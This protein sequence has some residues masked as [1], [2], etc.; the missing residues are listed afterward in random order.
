LRRVIC[1]LYGCSRAEDEDQK[2]YRRQKKGRHDERSA[3]LM[4]TGQ[5]VNDAIYYKGRENLSH[6]NSGIQ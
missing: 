1:C 5:D 2:E 3:R 4:R 6:A